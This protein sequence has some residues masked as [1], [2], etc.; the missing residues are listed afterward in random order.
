MRNSKR[1]FILIEGILAV[2]VVILI[3]MMAFQRNG[4]DL[5]KISVIVQNSDD[6]Q[7]SAFKYG[8]EMAAEDAG[9]E[10]IMVSTGSIMTVEE[11]KRIIEQEIE[12]GTDAVIVQPVSGS[13]TQEMLKDIEKKIPVILVETA[14]VLEKGG[15][16][17]ALVQPDNY[18]MGQMLAKEL[19]KDYNGN[20][21]GK[22]FGM[23]AQTEVSESVMNRKE[24]FLSVLED[25]GASMSWSLFGIS[26]EGRTESLKAQEKADFVIA[27]DDDSLTAAGKCASSN[28][29][30]GAILYGIGNSTESIYYLDTGAVECLV[31]PDEFN[32]GYRSLTEVAETLKHSFH[33][34]ESETVSYTVLRRDTL[35]LEENQEILFTMSQ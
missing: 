22:T 19:M 32:V 17:L 15:S 20:L 10:M 11:E 16:A 5:H 33:K 9:V 13:Y 27:L 35:F 1:V 8:L 3:C 12:N 6:D 18:E 31:V 7:W 14:A 26:A 25:S 2:L 4:K 24:G 23:I 28:N 21:E 29:L 34:L 30:H